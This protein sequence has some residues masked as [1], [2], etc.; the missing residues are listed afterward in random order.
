MLRSNGVLLFGAGLV[1]GSVIGW[2][3]KYPPVDSSSA[4]GWVQA[5]GSIAAI[6][7]AI[8]IA[9]RQAKADRRL[10][11]D[12]LR[13]RLESL[14]TMIDNCRARVAKVCAY[15]LM[16]PMLAGAKRLDD[17][18]VVAMRASI[19]IVSVLSPE[20]APTGTAAEALI[21]ARTAITNAVGII[22][23]AGEVFFAKFEKDL[24]TLR[25]ELK[26]AADELRGDIDR[27]R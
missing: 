5:I 13:D 3:I 4:A 23:K 16:A 17:D 21:R 14:W 2:L 20:M 1:A 27:R 15:S 22:P 8:V 6:G 11:V 19:E 25:D 7:A 24:E 26:S 18:L 9:S 12:E 10:R